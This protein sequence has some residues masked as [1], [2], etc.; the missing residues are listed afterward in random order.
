MKVGSLHDRFWEKVNKLGPIPSHRPRLGPCWLFTGAKLD[1]GYGVIWYNEKNVPATHVAIYLQTGE[2]IKGQALHKCDNPSCVRFSHLYEG[3]Q[4]ENI[5]D[6]VRK[7]RWP[8]RN[9]LTQ[10]QAVAIRSEY[11]KG[12]VTQKELGRLYKIS[13]P[14]I[15]LIVLGKVYKINRRNQCP[16][17]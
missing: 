2:W 10:E 9:L 1:A 11:K 17:H 12:K 6:A 4:K 3:T 13:Q 14:T 15:S 7:G 8:Y 16:Q 5:L